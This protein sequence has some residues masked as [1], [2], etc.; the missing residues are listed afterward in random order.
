VSPADAYKAALTRANRV[1]A[2]PGLF[3]AA[4][5]GPV[6][7]S[8]VDLSGVEKMFGMKFTIT[9]ELPA[10]VRLED[11][12][13]IFA[14]N[15]ESILDENGERVYDENFDGV[16]YHQIMIAKN[17]YIP[18]EVV[19]ELSEGI[20]VQAAL[21]AGMRKSSLIKQA[22]PVAPSYK[23]ASDE[24]TST[25]KEE[26][27]GGE[28]LPN[29][30]TVQK[31]T[32]GLT[33]QK[34]VEWGSTV[35]KATGKQDNANN[36]MSFIRCLLFGRDLELTFKAD[37]IEGFKL[38]DTTSP[39]N[40]ETVH[41]C[42]NLERKTTEETDSS[43]NIYA[44]AMELKSQ[45]L[46]VTLSQKEAYP[47]IQDKTVSTYD[48]GSLIKAFKTP[49][50]I[51]RLL[52]V[53]LFKV[54]NENST[55]KL[56]TEFNP[57]PSRKIPPGVDSN[58]ILRDD[59]IYSILTS[60][61]DPSERG[62]FSGARP[63]PD[64][65]NVTYGFL[66][67]KSKSVS[68]NA[69]KLTHKYFP[70]TTL[71]FRPNDE[72]QPRGIYDELSPVNE[73][74][75][76]LVWSILEYSSPTQGKATEEEVRIT[77]VDRAILPATLLPDA[78]LPDDTGNYP[79][80]SKRNLLLL[81]LSQLVYNTDHN[82]KQIWQTSLLNRFPEPKQKGGIYY[83]GGF[84]KDPV[85][86]AGGRVIKHRIHAFYRYIDDYEV[87]PGRVKGRRGNLEL[88]VV[89]RGSETLNDWVAADYEIQIGTIP[90]TMT[91]VNEIS[92]HIRDIYDK[93][94]EENALLSTT[95]IH[96]Q[97]NVKVFSA[98]HSLGGFL[99]L[100]LASKSYT[101][102]FTGGTLE[103]RVNKIET[104]ITIGNEGHIIPVV[105]NPYLGTYLVSTSLP[106][107]Y[108]LPL[109]I[110]PKGTIFRT[111]QD[112][113]SE[114][115]NKREFFNVVVNEFHQAYYHIYAWFGKRDY[116]NIDFMTRKMSAHSVSNFIG[117][118]LYSE[119]SQYDDEE[120]NI[121]YGNDTLLPATYTMPIRLLQDSKNAFPN[122]FEY[123]PP[124]QTKSLIDESKT[125]I[126]DTLAF[127]PPGA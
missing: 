66:P 86:K 40:P 69:F 111:F 108:A 112:V 114:L 88:Y 121:S 122:D 98:G 68:N 90:S 58:A 115:A 26:M 74:P 42:T 53:T 9:K 38:M 10:G 52:F 37:A 64:I 63:I 57:I 34:K 118:I 113:A 6:A 27:K 101:E 107:D 81:Y 45:V 96:N 2:A 124:E 77:S 110:I 23:Y 79:K 127:A 91:R 62:W 24:Q 94:A 46:S 22:E 29:G 123:L 20:D 4:L 92:Q 54:V 11:M 32:E 126:R 117:S 50:Q 73:D 30:I 102:E 44:T 49:S 18:E 35:L 80:M 36:I 99:A 65:V 105:V 72:K 25:E 106:P 120:A 71:T 61:Y 103:K 41:V 104:N 82:I 84:A 89:F 67:G 100:M 60:V 83:L 7:P 1:D 125:F 87:P 78:G 28:V 5:G 16:P 3:K 19:Q 75:D 97:R 116:T 47:L 39:I 95:P 15:C 55:S 17:T 43:H 13:V 70:C 85:W 76:H 31:T 33:L 48:E 12:P 14:G 51:K 56:Y 93:L 119:A 21:Y 59:L 109:C 8:E